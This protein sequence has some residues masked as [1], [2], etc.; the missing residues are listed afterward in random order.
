MKMKKKEKLL[1]AFFCVCA[2]LSSTLLFAGSWK[3][4][5]ALLFELT[6]VGLWYFL[7]LPACCIV[8]AVCAL[9]LFACYGRGKKDAPFLCQL[10]FLILVVL[11]SVSTL[12]LFIAKEFHEYALMR[13]GLEA[14]AAP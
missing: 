8:L 11:M 14:S 12:P 6:K 13:Q 7:G 3:V 9:K 2:F 1:T 10:G 4:A 5:E